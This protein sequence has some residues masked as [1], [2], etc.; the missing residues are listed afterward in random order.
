M[1]Q[2]SSNLQSTQVDQAGQMNG[3]PKKSKLL[4]VL[5]VV[6][7]VA[8]IALGIAWFF[9]SN[10]QDEED[11]TVKLNTLNTVNSVANTSNTTSNTTNTTNTVTTPTVPSTV[12]TQTVKGVS[13]YFQKDWNTATIENTTEAY[14]ADSPIA[15]TYDGATIKFNALTGNDWVSGFIGSTKSL[16]NDPNLNNKATIDALKLTYAN[17]KVDTNAIILA[18]GVVPKENAAVTIKKVNYLKNFDNSW[19]GYWTVSNISQEVGLGPVFV[20]MLYNDATGLSYSFRMGLTSSTIDN[21]EKQILASTDGSVLID[22]Y[23]ASGYESDSLV[24]AQINKALDL[25]N[26][27]GH[28]A[29]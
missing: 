23:V 4:I 22:N 24:M 14:N 19:R 5:I 3:S 8:L 21:I 25:L 7:A 26:L 2:D 20:A 10:R 27:T 11:A 29:Q 18:G 28:K 17:Q 9:L 6:L 1:V 12:T 15:T 16:A 13:L